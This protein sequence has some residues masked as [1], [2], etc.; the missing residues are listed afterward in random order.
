MTHFSS[1]RSPSNIALIKYWGK[2]GIQLPNN[3]SL[4]FTLS[5]C[6]TDMTMHVTPGSSKP[7]LNVLYDGSERPSFEPKIK[8]FFNRIADQLPWLLQS[9]IVIDSVNTFPHGAGIAS[10]AS[11][12]SAMALCLMDIDSQVN[13]RPHELKNASWWN[14]V[15]E[16]ARLGSGSACRSVFP[17][18]ALWGELSGISGSSNSYATPW[19]DHVSSIFH[20]YQDTI[21]IVSH[22]EKS[23][24]STEGHELM[25]GH[26]YEQSRYTEAQKNIL[27]L[28]E[29][30][31]KENSIDQFISVCE[32]EALQLHALMMSGQKPFILI[33]PGTVSIIKEVWRF[34][35]ETNIP[36]CFTLDAG[37]NV[38]LLYPASYKE[39]VLGWIKTN[40]LR[41]CTD[42][43]FIVDEVGS[44]PQK[45]L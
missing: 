32:S 45:I 37:P 6:H 16:L 34:R 26:A 5:A 40:L 41:Y 44:G 31:K 9:S 15:S 1:W 36:V 7:Q 4:S 23:V 29:S 35:N 19:A 10:S 11:S 38:H 2:H 30:M 13:A 27:I 3:P 33:E 20:D 18:A 14:T 8:S 24:S 28:I 42:G 22:A 17:V 21:L 39:S 12:M 25:S 43:L